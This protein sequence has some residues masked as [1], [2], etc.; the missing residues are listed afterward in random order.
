MAT[1]ASAPAPAPATIPA[2][3]TRTA[4]ADDQSAQC[5]IRVSAAASTRIDTLR[6]AT[7]SAD[8][9]ELRQQAIT[10]QRLLPSNLSTWALNVL[11][12]HDL[13]AR[14]CAVRDEARSECEEQMTGE[15]RLQQ[16]LADAEVIMNR[17]AC[18]ADPAQSTSRAEKIA[19]PDRFDGARE[20]LKVFKDQLMLKTSG[21]AAHIP[22]TQ[23]KLRYAYQFVTGKAQRT[24]RIH[25]RRTADPANGEETYEI[26]FDTFAAF[27]TALNRHFGDPDEKQTAALTLDKL[28]QASRKVS[29]YYTDFQ[30]LL[31]ILQNTDDTSRRHA[32]KRG[33]NHKMINALAIFPAPMD[34][35]FDA[36]VECLNELDCC[37]RVLNTHSHHLPTT[38]TAARS[39]RRALAGV[40]ADLTP[41]DSKKP[42]TIGSCALSEKA[43]EETELEGYQLVVA[44]QLTSDTSRVIP[45]YALIDNGATGFAFMEEDFAHRHHFPLIPLKTPRA[46]EVI[47]GRP[48]ASGM[49]IHLVHAKLQ[50]RNHVEN[51]F[52][53]ITRLGH[54]P[55]ILG[56]PWL[57]H[58]D[59]SI[60]F[61]TNKVTFDSEWCCKNHNAHGRPTW[62]KGLEFIPERPARPNRMA[63]I[64]CAAL[65]HLH[66]RK[67]LEI[68]S[69]SLR[70]VNAGL[71]LA[72]LG[73][74]LRIAGARNT[75]NP[76]N[77]KDPQK[78]KDPRNT[79][80]P[81]VLVPEHLHEF[82]HVFEKG[83]V[84]TLPP[85]C[86]YDHSIPLKPDSV[87]PFGT[88]YG[89]SHKELLVLKE[90][91][92]EN[93]AKG[94]IRHCSS[95]AGAPVLFVKKADGS[96][97]FCVDYRGLNEMAIKNRYPLPL[98]Q[99]T[100]A[101]LQ[102]ARWYTKLDLRDGYYHL[103]I[104][105][106][107]EWKT[108][109]RTRYGHFESQVMPF[110]LMNALGSFQHF[111]NDTIREFLDI[112]CTAF[113]DDILIYSSMLKVN[114][115]HVQLVL[116]RLTAADIHL[117][118]EK[119]RVHVQEVDYLGLV[120][121]PNGLRMQDE[122]VATIRR[123]EDPK[124][125]KDL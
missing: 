19:D 62:I 51:A 82:L 113:L 94:F 10:L 124:C 119:C 33:L 64:G 105:A 78:T 34:E 6:A 32:L 45:T 73:A 121:T 92:E 25:L 42:L 9:A 16:W 102:N 120:I 107:E 89:M 72:G 21:N 55:L 65:L 53:F 91:I 117:K 58:H 122:K 5:Y 29:T 52:F 99:E 108:A 48:I 87:P 24:M 36:Y 101:R 110:G 77:T 74:A 37:L 71:K 11:P 112:F 54:Y 97:R 22:N 63:F 39:S 2:I 47:D 100:L 114:K 98:M 96:L 4:T 80:D 1:P 81:H 104:T 109:F 103:R 59:S 118:P 60:R 8:P 90:Y 49:I 40:S 116:E 93:L 95:P 56:I 125:V 27:L 3:I 46:L 66:R 68:Q 88:L 15:G 79:K 84:Q 85:H 43:V 13:A 57:R 106:G 18:S 41:V 20:K 67:K 75:K 50:I 83:N 69:I 7:L 44:C 111:I 115:E 61:S 86:P 23:H 31:D 12:S 30:E 17:L 38:D 28:R 26:A 14:L 70:E 123:W 35:S 76:R